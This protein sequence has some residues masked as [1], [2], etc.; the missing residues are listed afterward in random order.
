ML[1][2]KRGNIVCDDVTYK[3]SDVM[4][5][6]N[7][8]MDRT[9]GLEIISNAPEHINKDIARILYYDMPKTSCESFP[10]LCDRYMIDSCAFE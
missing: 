9:M 3:I 5:Y 7:D 8:Y 1:D 4:I 6:V 10:Y 2:I